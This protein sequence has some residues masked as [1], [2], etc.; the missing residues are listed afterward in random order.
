MKCLDTDILV[1]ILRGEKEVQG[2]A[3]SLDVEGQVYTTVINAFEILFGAKKS[4][5]IENISETRK[6]LAKLSVIGM[7]LESA[8]NASDI[9]AILSKQGKSIDFRDLFIGAIVKSNGL[10]LITR[11][12]KHFSRIQGLQI[13]KW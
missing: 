10:K 7:E 8:E 6:L 1:A 11:N 3:E 9:H 13:E 2:I 4:N 5:N 12:H